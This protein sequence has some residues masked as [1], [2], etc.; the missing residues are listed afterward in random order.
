[1]AR[2]LAALTLLSLPLLASAYLPVG[3]VPALALKWKLQP[4]THRAGPRFAGVTGLKSASTFG[5]SAKAGDKDQVVR[6]RVP[7][8]PTT[9]CACASNLSYEKCCSPFHSS[10]TAP[11]DPVDLIRARYSAYA[12][13]LPGYVMRS[14]SRKSPD[15]TV[16]QA[17]WIEDIVDFCDSYRFK[18][19]GGQVLGMELEECTYSSPEV[20]YVQFKAKMLGPGYRPVELVE[21]SRVLR[22]NGRWFYEKGTL[23]EY[24]G[25]LV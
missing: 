13:R 24:Q 4:S 8:D 22:E 9:K 7:E 1:M 18:R 5:L 14:T 19:P 23:L 10:G 6:G 2:F 15:W 3:S 12:Y 20:C 16:N 21:R 11:E 25:D 17:A